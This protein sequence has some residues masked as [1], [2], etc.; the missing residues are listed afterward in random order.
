MCAPAGYGKTTLL[1]QWEAEDRKSTPFVWLTLEEADADP[2]DLWNQIIVGLHQAHPATGRKSPD[3][4]TA[5]PHAIAPVAIPLL[6]NELVDAAPL[7]LVL[8]DWHVLRSPLCDDTMR[9]FVE[10]AP[11]AVQVV[12]SSRADP[13]IGLARLRAHGDL[14]EVRAH[15]GDCPGGV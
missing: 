8:E 7:V 2:V 1:G 5:G 11:H 6:V 12:I 3:A 10:H 13:G 14:A 4:L 9:A 15:I